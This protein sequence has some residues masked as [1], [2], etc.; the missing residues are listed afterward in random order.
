M[1]I[2][3]YDCFSG[4]SGDMNLGAL[5]D[6]GVPK[7][8]II[9][10]LEKLNVSGYEI[11]VNRDMKKGISGTKVDVILTEEHHHNIEEKEHEHHHEHEGHVHSHKGL[12]EIQEIIYKSE[13]S[14]KVKKMSMD[15]FM[16]VAK[17]ESKVHNK[18]LYEV[19]FHEVGAIDSI[20]DT[21]G[22]A[23]AIDYLN[24]DKIICSSIELGGGFVKCQHGIIPVPAPAVVEILKDVPVKS[25][26]V[27]FE[28]TTPTGA[29]ILKA[30]A[31]EYSDNKEF[32]IKKVG[33]GLGKR[34]TDIPN[35]LRVF[36]AE[37]NK[38]KN[39]EVEKAYILECNI[40]DMNPE[41]Y[42]YIIDGLFQKGAADVFLTPIIMKKGRP[43]V[44]LSVLLNNEKYEAIEQFILCETS[45]LGFRKYEVEKTML[46][47]DFIK[48]NTKYGEVTIK[49]GYYK[50]KKVKSKPEYTE[51]K[52]L[53]IKNEVT[54]KEIYDEINK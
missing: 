30:M 13:L 15:I 24:V 51:C 44:K 22:A 1:K 48:I 54:L 40:D 52:E 5:I 28:T 42:D 3:Y 6:I 41:F 39:L 25:G 26:K 19:H 8:Y 47:R 12:K 27:Q 43:A 49:N 31:S 32:S 9:S 36:L 23:I 20:V 33:Y 46:K 17:A 16:Q 38:D 29:A 7:D 11:T 35:V 2:L 10:E 34:D 4:I 14:E 37:S 45:T 53:A 50:G 21:V 18:P